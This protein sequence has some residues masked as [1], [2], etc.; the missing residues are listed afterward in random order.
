MEDILKMIKKY[1]KWIWIFFAGIP[2]LIYILSS[3][4]I[5]PVGGNNDWAGFW[6]GYIGAIIGGLVTLIGIDL[7]IRNTEDNRKKDKIDEIKP[8]LIL[9]PVNVSTAAEK[10]NISVDNMNIGSGSIS[11]IYIYCQIKNIGLNSA[12]NIIGNGAL[13]FSALEKSEIGQFGIK[14]SHYNRAE[15]KVTNNFKVEI[16]F[17]DLRNNDYRQ[18]AEFIF[19]DPY[20]MKQVREFTLT[21]PEPINNNSLP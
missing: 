6:G 20:D 3:V 9:I 15:D 1:K 21:I 8:Y 11:T 14:F 12:V 17:K 13:M 10:V 18:V 16:N 19:S 4:P 7:T 2:S 5:F